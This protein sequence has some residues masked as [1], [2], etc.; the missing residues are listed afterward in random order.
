MGSG[1]DMTD[2]ACEIRSV[3][4]AGGIKLVAY[5]GKEILE[6]DDGKPMVLAKWSA[7]KRDFTE[8]PA[9]WDT[10]TIAHNQERFAYE[11]D[12]VQGRLALGEE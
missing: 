10:D 9:D 12:Q 4:H 11:W 1:T 6:Y 3:F 5:T 8:R 7:A 2:D